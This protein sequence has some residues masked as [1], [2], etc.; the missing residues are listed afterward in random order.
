MLQGIRDRATGVLAWVIVI[1]IAI[2]F[3]LWGIQQYFSGGKEVVVASVNG[4]D[5]KLAELDRAYQ[6][7]RQRLGSALPEGVDEKAIKRQVLDALINRLLL[8]QTVQGMGLHVTDA[9]L[10]GEIES[11]PAFQQGGRFDRDA[12]ARI[13]QSQGLT[14][15]AFEAQLRQGMLL[16]QL[17]QGIRASHGVTS[18]AV[19]RI[20]LLKEQER[21]FSHLVVP[22]ARSMEAAKVSDQAVGAYY[23]AHKTQLTS[24]EQ[25]DLAYLE[26]KVGD[27]ARA[28]P[29]PSE[30]ALHKVYEERKGD[31]AVEEQRR[32]RHI[33]VAVAHDAPQTAAQAAREKAEKLLERIKKGENMGDLAREFSEDPGSAKQGGDLGYF[34]QG[35]MDPAMDQVVFSMRPGEI[36]L[37][38]TSYGFHVVKLEDV[39]PATVKPF[40]EVRAQLLADYRRREAE[41]E[42]LEK[43]E[44]LGD[45]TYEHP[46]TLEL[47]AK[48]LNLAIKT[49]G[50]FG[51]GG[52]GGIAA[53]PK[54][55]TAA[56]SQ[57]VLKDGYNSQAIELAP[58]DLVVVRVRDH[59]PSA[60]R[61]LA[62]VRAEIEQRLRFQQA[63]AEVKDLGEKLLA[64]LRQGKDPAAL[65]QGQG[66]EWAPTVTVK[67][68]DHSL[69]PAL[70]S[71]A[72]A[73]PRPGPHGAAYG[74]VVF[75]TGDCVLVRL[76][77]V[78]D[79]D[80]GK[81]D[82]KLRK[83]A[84]RD[85]ARQL[86][87]D[88]FGDWMQTLRQEA[89]VK[90]YSER[91]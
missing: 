90:I 57:E 50:F 6:Q 38:R 43:G 78:V 2:P 65:A 23:E 54:V 67:R 47:A 66:L 46:D 31:F 44:K 82:E 71:T 16:D 39:K 53:N 86:G 13:L 21:E 88:D 11:L 40:Q 3:A 80:L 72:F 64:D 51:R 89:D 36:R 81:V 1:L 70:L 35:S 27:L 79:G 42:F 91:L 75:P 87:A 84:A 68:D 32:A 73:L 34:G 41:R 29:E 74:S 22:V 10:G 60:V 9:Q 14:S 69:N 58:D 61:P 12:Y 63:K 20:L 48:E 59:K 76:T 62:D 56:F 19:N 8:I 85:L 15:A 7:E 49:T 52:G 30:D 4:R 25:V 5:I 33:L 55:L 37:A 17:G 45:L 28:I 83:A 18:E 24:P 26:L 77:G